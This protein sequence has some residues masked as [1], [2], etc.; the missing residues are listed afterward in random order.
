MTG[1]FVSVEKINGFLF[2]CPNVTVIE[3]LT[4]KQAK[5]M[6]KDD[7]GPVVLPLWRQ[8]GSR[9]PRHGEVV[10]TYKDFTT[11][12]AMAPKL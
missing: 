8:K 10:A 7:A 12:Y 4:A 3:V 1:T 5:A 6:E 2:S 9:T 11:L